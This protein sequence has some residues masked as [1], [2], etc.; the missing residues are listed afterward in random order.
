MDPC[1]DV[2]VLKEEK[3]EEK[4][5]KKKL[6]VSKGTVQ[7][8]S[9]KVQ[10]KKVNSSNYREYTAIQSN[11]SKLTNRINPLMMHFM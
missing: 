8:S 7:R 9:S 1:N 3:E 2:Q 10:S 4:R 11:R 6:N 5:R